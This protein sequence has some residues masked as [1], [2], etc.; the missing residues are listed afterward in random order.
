MRTVHH[1]HVLGPHLIDQR[2]MLRMRNPRTAR[3]RHIEKVMIP[4]DRTPLAFAVEPEH[5]S[6]V[7]G[8]LAVGLVPGHLPGQLMKLRRPLV[9]AGN[10][11][12]PRLNRNR[13][14]IRQNRLEISDQTNIPRIGTQQ[15][16]N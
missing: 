5:D 1:G 13:P 12:V 4:G 2:I 9:E 16:I 11:P 6:I 7:H 15:D 10:H 14:L 8:E 3:G